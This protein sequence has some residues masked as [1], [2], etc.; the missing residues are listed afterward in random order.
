M[1]TADPGVAA[2]QVRIVLR[3]IGSP[4]PLGFAAFGIGS[5][6]FAMEQPWVLQV[7]LGPSVNL[8]LTVFLAP[9]QLIAALCCFSARETLAATGL[10]L[11]SLS[12]PAVYVVSSGL[13]PGM[14]SP[15]LGC[16]YLVLS[17]F[18][19]LLAAPG[20][21][22]KPL[23]GSLIVVA[24]TRFLFGGLYELTESTNLERVA[25]ILGLLITLIGLYGALA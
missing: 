20:L 13:E 18:L 3:P 12:W 23:I 15:V 6:W 14:T 22:G 16:F 10:S 5:F 1:T 2:G 8:L 17:A 11:L 7:R 9:L 24:A 21:I 19:L 25:G 4:L